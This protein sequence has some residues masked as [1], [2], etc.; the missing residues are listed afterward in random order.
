[1]V[2][3]FTGDAWRGRGAES[4]FSSSFFLPPHCMRLLSH[5]NVHRIA[6]TSITKTINKKQNKRATPPGGGGTSSG[7]RRCCPFVI[8]L[9]GVSTVSAS[10]VAEEAKESGDPVL[11]L[12]GTGLCKSFRSSRVCLSRL[13]RSLRCLIF[14]MS[15]LSLESEYECYCSLHQ[16]NFFFLSTFLPLLETSLRLLSSDISVRFLSAFSEVCERIFVAPRTVKYIDES[17]FSYE[18]FGEKRRTRKKRGGVE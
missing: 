12:F 11:V 5:A 15:L 6:A 17:L 14:S 9:F 13:A 4:A 16:T 8:V 7:I 2:A 18:Y 10:S 1:M 3:G